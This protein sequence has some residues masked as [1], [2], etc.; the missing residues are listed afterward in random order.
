MHEDAEEPDENVKLGIG[1]S[2]KSVSGRHTKDS[3]TEALLSP[4][5][6]ECEQPRFGLI[7]AR[8][9]GTKSR[10]S[11]AASRFSV[12][13]GFLIFD[14]DPAKGDEELFPT[15]NRQP[16]ASPRVRSQQLTSRAGR[17]QSLAH[18]L[19]E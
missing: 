10:S 2:K 3:P 13:D 9:F 17:P 16:R 7:A 11:I 6:R 18:T 12:V 8:P 14:S 5:A 4:A 15:Q 19:L 1:I